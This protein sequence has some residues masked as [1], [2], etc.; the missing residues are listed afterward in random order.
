MQ[1]SCQ[2]SRTNLTDN[3]QDQPNDAVVST[4][5]VDS[6]SVG[7]HH[8]EFRFLVEELGQACISDEVPRYPILFSIRELAVIRLRHSIWP[9]L[10]SWPD[11]LMKRSLVTFLGRRDS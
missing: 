11:M 7:G 9:K 10:V 2:F 8:Q 1:L 3:T 4:G 5:Q 6:Q